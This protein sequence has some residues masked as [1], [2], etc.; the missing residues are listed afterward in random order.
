[1]E[2]P[3]CIWLNRWKILLCKLL[4]TVHQN[5]LIKKT[6]SIV[7]LTVCNARYEFTL[8]DIGDSGRQ[9]DGSVYNNSHLG[10]AIEQNLLNI[11]K[12][13]KINPDSSVLYPF[14]F[15]ADDAFGLKPHMMKPD[16][17]QNLPIDQRIFNCRLPRAMR[18]IENI[19]GIST[20]RFRIFRRPIIAKTEKVKLITK[21]VVALHI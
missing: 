9:S 20:S 15:V 16:P 12:P 17:N 6:H 13:E 19:F 3:T 2:F 14:V 8:V 7:L 21:A 18:V 1:M 4:I 5:I 10:H 11:R